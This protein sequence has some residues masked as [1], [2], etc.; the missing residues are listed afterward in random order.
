[1]PNPSCPPCSRTST[2]PSA[3]YSTAPRAPRTSSSA[4][5]KKSACAGAPRA[6]PPGRSRRSSTSRNARWS[7]T[8]KMPPTNSASSTASRPWRAP[9]PSASSPLNPPDPVSPPQHHLSDLTVMVAAPSLS[10]YA[11]H[12]THF[13]GNMITS[14]TATRGGEYGLH[15][16]TINKMFRFRAEM[17]CNRLKWPLELT[18]GLEKDQY[19]ALNPIYLLSRT[20]R[21]EI[22]S[23]ARLLPTTGRYM[24][25]EVFSQMLQGEAAPAADDVWELR[26]FDVIPS[27]GVEPQ[28]AV[29][30]PITLRRRRG[31]PHPTRDWRDAVRLDR[32][33][34]HGAHIEQHGDR[35]RHPRDGHMGTHRLPLRRGSTRLRAAG[36]R[37][38]ETRGQWQPLFLPGASA[39]AGKR[40]DPNRRGGARI[41]RTNQTTQRPLLA[42]QPSVGRL[43]ITDDSF[44]RHRD[45]PVF[46]KCPL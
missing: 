6:R 25:P 13:G 43:R 40:D 35:E 21:N 16:A 4:C 5:A 10:T 46:F 19:D 14:I 31:G 36:G 45:V 27:G 3:C 29:L 8:C 9:S 20:A 30:H 11:R 42:A 34:R 28:Q 15:S 37:H 41:P 38:A 24:L 32:R 1:M 22:E 23:C 2:R 12:G 33:R 18:D 17:F 26:R 39:L 44:S 7:F